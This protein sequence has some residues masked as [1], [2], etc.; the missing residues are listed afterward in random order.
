MKTA[1]TLLA[2]GTLFVSPSLSALQAGGESTS[3]SI[4]AGIPE[5]DSEMSPDVLR[6]VARGDQLRSQLRFADA[7]VE[8]R[9]GRHRA[10]RGTLA[11][12]DHV[13]AGERPLQ[14]R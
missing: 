3:P 2:V 5:S 9:H 6:L 8:Y 1:L 12:R 13:D 4:R 7:A 11:E 10:A 14:R